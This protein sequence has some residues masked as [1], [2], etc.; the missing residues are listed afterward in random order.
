MSHCFYGVWMLVLLLITLILPCYILLL[1]SP[2]E[3][4]NTV[5][6]CLGLFTM[7]TTSIEW[8]MIISW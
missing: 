1:I 7:F 4:V 6:D 8:H 2:N 5:S 3:H